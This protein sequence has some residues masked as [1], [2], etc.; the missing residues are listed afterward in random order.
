M[1]LVVVLVERVR[2]QSQRVL[3]AEALLLLFLAWRLFARWRRQNP[4]GAPEIYEDH[5]LFGSLRFTTSRAEYLAEGIQQ[6]RDGQFSFWYGGNHVVVVS[7]EAARIAFQTS[8]GL[9]PSAG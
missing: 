1:V 6:S 2:S 4:L 3:A 9:D 8:R 5:G 7:G